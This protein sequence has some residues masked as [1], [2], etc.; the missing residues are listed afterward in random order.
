[1]KYPSSDLVWKDAKHNNNEKCGLTILILVT[2]TAKTGCR[3]D[4]KQDTSWIMHH[5]LDARELDFTPFE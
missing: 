3:G 2:D 4:K 1:M 5:V